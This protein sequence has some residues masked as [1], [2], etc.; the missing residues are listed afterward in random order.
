MY[1]QPLRDWSQIVKPL[2][3]TEYL[4]YQD[5][6]TSD[7][8]KAILHADKKSKSF[9]D[10]K[11]VELLRGRNDYETCCRVWAFVRAN[12]RYRADRPGHERVKSPGALFGSGYGD[13]KSFSVAVGALLRALGIPFR[14]RFAAYKS[15]DYTHVY[16]V[17]RAGGRLVPVDATLN[18]CDYEARAVRTGDR[19]PGDQK[20]ISGPPL[21]HG[22]ELLL[23]GLA[24]WGGYKI[25]NRK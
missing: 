16:I 19:Y 11:N 6:D 10:R 7:I 21:I 2:D 25:L 3:N 14:Y 15:G 4:M 22:T 24:L 1:I 12:V 8:I 9:I 23:I 5:G 18:E 20:S 13:C 17:A